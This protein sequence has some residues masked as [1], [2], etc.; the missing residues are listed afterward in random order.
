MKKRDQKYEKYQIK[1]NAIIDKEIMAEASI[2]LE[3]AILER[4]SG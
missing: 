1:K 3:K 4:F 2:Y